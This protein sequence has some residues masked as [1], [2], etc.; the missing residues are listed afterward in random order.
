MTKT[1]KVGMMPGTINEYAVE[2]GTTVREVLELAGLSASGYDV[3]IDGTKITDFEQTVDNANLVL[4]V[5]QVKG[6]ANGI[7][8]VGMMPGTINEYAIEPGTSIQE[9]LELAGLSASGYDVKVDGEKVTDLS[10]DAYD[11]NLILLVK[12]VKGN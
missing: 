7:V 5:K 12:Q 3:K 6:N 4:L 11:A 9:V 10:E 8:K 2:A 1:I